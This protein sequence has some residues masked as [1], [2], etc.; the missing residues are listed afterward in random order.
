MNND[1]L[2]VLIPLMGVIISGLLSLVIS[3]HHNKIEYIKAQ[4]EFSGQL[5]SARLTAYPEI[6]ELISEFLKKIYRNEN[7]SYTELNDFYKMYSQLDSKSGLLFSYT[8]KSSSALME[9]IG[10]ILKNCSN[11]ETDNIFFYDLKDKLRR[12]LADVENSMKYELGVYIYK[13]PITIMKKLEL[14]KTGT[15]AQNKVYAKNGI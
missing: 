10:E 4:S 3:K 1:M 12:K 2:I 15:E 7:I 6:Y 9:G 13:N 8:A 14:T 5:Y 11:D